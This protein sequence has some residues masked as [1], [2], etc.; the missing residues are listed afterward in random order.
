MKN[1]VKNGYCETPG[2]QNNQKGLQNAFYM[3]FLSGKTPKGAQKSQSRGHASILHPLFGS[4]FTPFLSTLSK[5]TK[6]NEP[7]S[8]QKGLL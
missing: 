3:R 6:M 5:E 1:E 8:K 7:K 4:F 2:K